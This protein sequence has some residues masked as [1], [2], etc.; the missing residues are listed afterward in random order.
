MSWNSRHSSHV[1]GFRVIVPCWHA[2]PLG[3]IGLQVSTNIRIKM[4]YSPRLREND[5][6]G[7][8]D[9][10]LRWYYGYLPLKCEAL[11]PQHISGIRWNEEALMLLIFIL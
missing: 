4:L 11:F 10:H 7:E 5:R 3:H 8:K 1:S 6:A 2:K 9:T